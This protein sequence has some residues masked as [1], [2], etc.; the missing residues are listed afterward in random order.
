MIQAEICIRQA[1]KYAR[2]VQQEMMPELFC[3]VGSKDPKDDVGKPI[4]KHEKYGASNVP[5]NE[6][7]LSEDI[8]LRNHRQWLQTNRKGP[9]E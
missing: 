3:L 4:E 5:I 7:I 8:Q 9:Q 1:L 2:D 6:A